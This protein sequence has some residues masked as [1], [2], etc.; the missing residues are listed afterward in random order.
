ME[1][2]LKRMEDHFESNIN[3]IKELLKGNGSEGLVR[4]VERLDKWSS[5]FQA[6][7]GIIVSIL[8]SIFALAFTLVKDVVA[9]ILKIR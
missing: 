3:E 9:N 7:M 6:R 4:R 2:R 1:E 8:G 5:D